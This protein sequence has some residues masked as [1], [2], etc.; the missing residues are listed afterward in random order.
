MKRF[1]FPCIALA[2]LLAAACSEDTPAA[3][4]ESGRGAV[5]EDDSSRWT[6]L[7]L[8]TGE[9]VGTAPLGDARSD[10]LWAG[11]TDW[12][13]AVC[14]P[15]LRTNGGTSGCGSGGI[16]LSDAPY[17]LTAAPPVRGLVTDRDTI[18]IW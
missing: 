6:Y 14:G 17:E 2:G 7:S 9:V 12:D 18:E 11:R 8:A 1:L 13:I 10:S 3:F 16:G 5:F 4:P 15:Y